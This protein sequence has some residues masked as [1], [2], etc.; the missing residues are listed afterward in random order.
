M[1]HWQKKELASLEFHLQNCRGRKGPV[2]LWSD[3]GEMNVSI[4]C[5]GSLQKGDEEHCRALGSLNV[6]LEMVLD[7]MNLKRKA[8]GHISCWTLVENLLCLVVIFQCRRSHWFQNGELERP[9]WLLMVDLMAPCS[10]FHL[11]FDSFIVIWELVDR[12]HLGRTLQ[13]QGIRMKLGRMS[14]ADEYEPNA[15][16]PLNWRK[17]LQIHTYIIHTSYHMGDDGAFTFGGSMQHFVTSRAYK[18]AWDGVSCLRMV[19]EMHRL[20]TATV[21]EFWIAYLVHWMDS[22]GSQKYMIL[23][24]SHCNNIFWFDVFLF[25]IMQVVHFDQLCACEHWPAL[26]PNPLAC[27]TRL[28]NM[29]VVMFGK[30]S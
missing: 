13:L 2:S 10:P 6:C 22:T 20:R 9:A 19:T 12:I 7:A 27:G 17:Y 15:G 21:K 3:I 25:Y 28:K 4:S 14:I 29:N 23:V 11:L 5:S 30:S 8:N 24:I 16:T 18:G 1:N 26:S